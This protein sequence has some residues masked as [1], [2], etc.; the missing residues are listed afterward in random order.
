MGI[1]RVLHIVS[2][3]DRGG[4]ETLIMNVYRNIDRRKIQFD[5]V[6]HRSE[7][8]S[9]DNEIIEMG[10]RIHRI[11][12]LGSVRTFKIYKKIDRD[13]EFISH[14]LPYIRTPIFKVAFQL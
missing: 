4:A 2:A 10:G 7:K 14:I 5:F 11:Q 12:S 1:K 8:G 13:Y 3:M 6:V 9:F